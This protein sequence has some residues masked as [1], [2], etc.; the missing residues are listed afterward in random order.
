MLSTQDMLIPCL[1]SKVRDI[2]V[3]DHGAYD[4]LRVEADT[5]KWTFEG[6]TVECDV[7]EVT[8]L[9]KDAAKCAALL[10]SRLR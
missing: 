3:S 9:L 1:L 8:D 6:Q 2:L 7:P 4:D 5:I 10:T